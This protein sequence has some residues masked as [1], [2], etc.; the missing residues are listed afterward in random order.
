MG[1]ATATIEMQ[2]PE[3]HRERLHDLVKATRTVLVLS[4]G[5]GDGGERIVGRPMALLRTA[6]DTTMFVG[7]SLDARQLAD[8]QRDPRV[9]VALQRA[10]YALFD[11]EA[12]I[13]R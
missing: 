13:S 5:R 9:T 1:F 12:M 4:W 11:A 3:E 10:G 6:D 8:L 7:T 2:A